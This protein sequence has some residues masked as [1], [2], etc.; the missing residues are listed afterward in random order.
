M[1]SRKRMMRTHKICPHCNKEINIKTFKDHKRLY[2]NEVSKTWIVQSVSKRTISYESDSSEC[3]LPPSMPELSESEEQSD[4][5]DLCDP[6]D[7]NP[8]ARHVG[9]SS[10]SSPIPQEGN[11]GIIVCEVIFLLFLQ[12]D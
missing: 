5:V 11:Y 7:H 9:T 3:S 10:S 8:D 1:L 6:T 12:S 4:E 2:Y